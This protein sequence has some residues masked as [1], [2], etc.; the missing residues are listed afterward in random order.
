MNIYQIDFNV[1]LFD[2]DITLSNNKRRNLHSE[3]ISPF[4]YYSCF[5]G[6]GVEPLSEDDQEKR[7]R[8]I[9]TIAGPTQ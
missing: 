8:P 4:C 7:V 1:Y 9:A 2:G 6:S 3:L 5:S